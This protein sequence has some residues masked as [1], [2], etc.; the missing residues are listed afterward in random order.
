MLCFL[1]GNHGGG[2]IQGEEFHI[3]QNGFD[4]CDV[5][6]AGK[7]SLPQGPQEAQGHGPYHQDREHIGHPASSKDFCVAALFQGDGLVV[8]V[9][10]LLIH[11]ILIAEQIPFLCVFPVGQ[12]LGV[13]PGFPEMPGG[14]LVS[15]VFL[16]SIFHGKDGIGP[17]KN[18][19]QNRQAPM[20]GSHHKKQAKNLDNVLGYGQQIFKACHKRW[21]RI[22]PDTLQKLP[23]ILLF[24][25]CI[26]D[27][28]L[29]LQNLHG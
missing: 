26:G 16:F 24:Q 3:I 25:V 12:G 7:P 21:G 17:Q 20:L 29:L 15:G 11:P 1:K 5:E 4:G 22:F 19:N 23:D 14:F 28:S 10:P 8:L 9:R 27:F 2:E 6:A 13:V 18:G